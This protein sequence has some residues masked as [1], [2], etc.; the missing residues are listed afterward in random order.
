VSVTDNGIGMPADVLER[1]FEP[2]FTTKGVGEGTG[3]GL[4]QVYGFARQS[5]G[6]VR[7]DSAL[8]R[9]TTVTILLPRSHEKSVA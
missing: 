3:L 6:S 2:F 8:G 5:N 9:G 7:I 4:S 1:V